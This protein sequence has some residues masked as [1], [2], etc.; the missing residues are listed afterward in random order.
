MPSIFLPGCLPLFLGP[1]YER[2]SMHL[3]RPMSADRGFYTVVA[4]VVRTERL[5]M[6]EEVRSTKTRTRAAA[7]R[8]FAGV[9]L[10]RRETSDGSGRLKGITTR[11]LQKMA[12][13]RLLHHF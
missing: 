10:F 2:R 7:M 8:W 4:Q 11:G 13:S 12:T 5:S 6:R 3:K 9:Q 1:A